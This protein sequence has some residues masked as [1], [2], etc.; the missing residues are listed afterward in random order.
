LPSRA[1]DPAAGSDGEREFD[2]RARASKQESLRYQHE[3]AKALAEAG[4]RIRQ[5]PRG[6]NGESSP[7]YDIE[8]RFFDWHTPEANT[9]MDNVRTTLRRK[10]KKNQSEF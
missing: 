2:L 8:G 10:I 5:L 9:S 7:D 6:Q 1:P 4:Y 3:A